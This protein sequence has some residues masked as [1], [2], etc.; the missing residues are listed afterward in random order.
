MAD[1]IDHP[2][3]DVGRVGELLL[4]LFLSFRCDISLFDVR[5]TSVGSI[6]VSY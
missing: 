2:R 4:V 1:D 5:K 3:E 6:D